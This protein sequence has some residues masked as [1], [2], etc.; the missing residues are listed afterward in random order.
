MVSDSAE[1][2]QILQTCLE[3]IH[4]GHETV[5][6][7]LAHYPYKSEQLRLELQAAVWFW[8]QSSAFDPRPG[9]ISASRARLVNRIRQEPCPLESGSR[10]RFSIFHLN[11]KPPLY[12]RMAAIMM[13]VTFAIFS[14]SGIAR[15]SQN[16]LP[17]DPLYKVKIGLENV[18]L[19]LSSNS[20]NDANLHIKFARRRLLEMQM[21]TL[22]GH[23]EE[24]APL[25]QGYEHHIA[26]ALLVMKGLATTDPANLHVLANSLQETATKQ[27]QFMNFLSKSVPA[28]T[29]QAFEHVFRVSN[30]S[31]ATINDLLVLSAGTPTLVSAPE[32]LTPTGTQTLVVELISTVAS[33]S[34]PTA[35]SVTE[36]VPIVTSLQVTTSTVM[37][38][39]EVNLTPIPIFIDTPKP[40][41]ISTTL[42]SPVS[43]TPIIEDVNEPTEG[44]E[45]TPKLTKTPKPTKEPKPAKEPKPTKT[46]KDKEK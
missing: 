26:Q 19:T 9:Y 16:A 32:R 40:S 23:F 36:L 22:E 44:L 42:V 17:G 13:L 15:A 29:K 20:I 33:A 27:A 5:D 6:S 41:S 12:L 45:P 39:V 1:L 30:E 7:C 14:T 46:P 34:T 11:L 21:L 8:G 4:A 37:V 43:A 35:P 31:L 18:A 28:E 38:A 24:V 10:V 3:D 2:D 25:A